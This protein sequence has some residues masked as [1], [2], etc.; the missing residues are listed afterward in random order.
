MSRVSLPEMSPFNLRPL[1]IP[2]RSTEMWIRLVVWELWM[3]MLVCV[4]LGFGALLIVSAQDRVI[5]VSDFSNCYG[6]PPVALPCERIVYRGGALYALFS[7]LCGVLLSGV[8]VWLLWELWTAV[9]PKPIEDDFL[10][11]LSDSFRRRWRDPRTWPWSRVFWAYG[12]T[13]VGAIMT[14]GVAVVLW[15]LV[16]LSQPAPTP[17]VRVET[18]QNFSLGK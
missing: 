9:Q 14:A 18:S 10:R 1:T 5:A 13:A 8:A 6:P 2:P 11:L 17:A 12:F 16:A 7:A 15:T 3:G 4:I